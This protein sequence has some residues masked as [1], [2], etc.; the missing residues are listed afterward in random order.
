MSQFAVTVVGS[1][2]KRPGKWVVKEDP[3][4]FW[5]GFSSDGKEEFHNPLDGFSVGETVEWDDEFVVE[6]DSEEQAREQGEDLWWERWGTLVE[7]DF[8]DV[9]EFEVV[10]ATQ[11]VEL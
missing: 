5:V 10:E 4:G 2:T 3:G 8:G 1:W 11:V 9:D 7:L 6:A